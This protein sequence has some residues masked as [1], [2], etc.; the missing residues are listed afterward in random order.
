[1]IAH[2]I[3]Y[4]VLLRDHDVDHADQLATE[5]LDRFADHCLVVVHADT[6]IA[7]IACDCMSEDCREHGCKFKRQA[8][9]G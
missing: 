8:A 1:M 6:V 9:N 2:D 3:I 4:N 7:E 5:I